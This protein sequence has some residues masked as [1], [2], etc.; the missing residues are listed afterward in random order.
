MKK[1]MHVN[2]TADKWLLSLL[3]TMLF[4]LAVEAQDGSIGNPYVLN[5][6][7]KEGQTGYLT[8]GKYYRI[9]PETNSGVATKEFIEKGNFFFLDYFEW[10]QDNV[11]LF[12]GPTGHYDVIFERHYENDNVTPIPS[13]I[14]TGDGDTRSEVVDFMK[15]WPRVENYLKDDDWQKDFTVNKFDPTKIT[16][17]LWICGGKTTFNTPDFDWYPFDDDWANGHSKFKNYNTNSEITYDAGTLSADN[18]A[19]MPNINSSTGSGQK[20]YQITLTTGRN[21]G[22]YS[23]NGA[24]NPAFKIYF[25]H[26][27]TLSTDQNNV[28]NQEFRGA[29]AASPYYAMQQSAADWFDFMEITDGGNIQPKQITS[30]SGADTRLANSDWQQRLLP[31]GHSFTFY[32][33]FNEDNI[34]NLSTQKAILHIKRNFKYHN[35]DDDTDN[36]YTVDLLNEKRT[37]ETITLRDALRFQLGIDYENHLSTDYFR[38]DGDKTFVIKHHITAEDLAFL[39]QM[40]QHEKEG[41]YLFKKL[42]L[43]QATIEGNAI[44]EGFAKGCT[45]FEKIYLPNTI[46]EIKEGA[47]EGCTNLKVFEVAGTQPVVVGKNAFKGCNQPDLGDDLEKFIKTN[48]SGT[49]AESAFE[50]CTGITKVDLS[51]GNVSNIGT[52]AFAGDKNIHDVYVPKGTLTDASIKGHD[53]NDFT[54]IGSIYNNKEWKV[55]STS[56]KVTLQAEDFNTGNNAGWY[57][58]ATSSEDSNYREEN[59][60]LKANSAYSNGHDIGYN[61][62]GNGNTW[63]WFNYTFYCEE[64]GYYN[65]TAG[66]G[67][68]ET[69]AADKKVEI[70]FTGNSTTYDVTLPSSDMKGWTT[71]TEEAATSPVLLGKGW[72]Y[73]HVYVPNGGIELDYYTLQWKEAYSPEVGNIV[74]STDA[75]AWEGIDA[76]QCEVHFDGDGEQSNYKQYRA[77][78]QNGWMYLLTKDIWENNSNSPEEAKNYN[79]CHQAHADVR[80]NRTMNAGWESLVLP[81]DV[82]AGTDGDATP[83][84]TIR[85]KGGAISYAAIFYSD[86][87]DHLIFLNVGGHNKT[88][89]ETYGTPDYPIS[90]GTP[91][92]VKVATSQDI[93]TFQNVETNADPSV[94]EVSKDYYTYHGTFNAIPK[95]TLTESV[96]GLS[97]GKIVEATKTAKFKGY[98][99]WFTKNGTNPTEGEA[100]PLSF[101]TFNDI[102]TAINSI[103]DDSISTTD[104]FYTTSGIR[105]TRPQKGLYITSGGKKIIIK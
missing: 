34:T 91:V 30:A 87:K 67:S 102:V 23:A 89:G 86:S 56:G 72:H 3:L 25:S 103:N 80:L 20:R 24:Q 36:N 61:D 63:H 59:H 27:L 10:V 11:F 40:I 2:R 5:T 75:S 79:V 54:G 96:W 50:N 21:Y 70:T 19:P 93:Y 81:F 92:V 8:N 104:V 16:G 46:A 94:S 97:N 95:Y 15:V 42:D 57:H 31:S 32:L 45:N 101:D 65:I 60:G 47:F 66:L 41:N 99:G 74:E 9:L 71:I 84:T 26:A 18:F 90:A 77:E 69:N 22:K 78:S 33:D 100:K 58:P 49:I 44:P 85:S 17:P 39:Q 98:R 105:T 38:T 68:G 43:R 14:I 35:E 82:Y 12:K 6:T 62:P 1:Q 55:S 51:N 48:V 83:E 37:A 28:H 29:N 64:T 7:Q 13:A 4:S 76:N 52:R 73:M 88:G 53:T